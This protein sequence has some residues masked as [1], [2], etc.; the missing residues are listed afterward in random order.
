MK[1]IT[2]SVVLV[3]LITFIFAACKKHDQKTTAEKIEG[4]WKIHSDITDTYVNNTHYYD[5][6]LAQPGSTVEFRKDGKVYSVYQNSKDT[7]TYTLSGDTKIIIDDE[8]YDI[9]TLNSNTFEISAKEVH[10]QN[11]VE[12][13]LKLIK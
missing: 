1:K 4:T 11:Y 12:E 10:G 2:N 13:T 6:T 9:K 3:V 5:T 7:S 8:P